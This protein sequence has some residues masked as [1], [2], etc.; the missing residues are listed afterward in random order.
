[1]EAIE[2]CAR[3]TSPAGIAKIKLGFTL[4]VLSPKLFTTL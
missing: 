2:C 4:E 3:K 1:V